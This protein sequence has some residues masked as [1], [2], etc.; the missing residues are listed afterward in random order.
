MEERVEYIPS[1]HESNS[2]CIKLQSHHNYHEMS[3]GD[4]CFTTII[5]FISYV[6]KISLTVFQTQAPHTNSSNDSQKYLITLKTKD[7]QLKRIFK[8]L[9]KFMTCLQVYVIAFCKTLII[10]VTLFSRGHQPRFIHETLFSRLVIYSSIILNLE[11]IGEDFIFASLCSREFTRNKVLA[12]KKC[13][14]VL[15]HYD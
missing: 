2:C 9:Y 11:I 5:L 4:F 7:G 13:L 6:W 15:Q 3:P 12:N 1:V 8:W 10:R 14:T